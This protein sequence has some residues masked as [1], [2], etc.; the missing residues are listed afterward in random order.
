MYAQH[1]LIFSVARRKRRR[2]DDIVGDDE[3]T[4]KQLGREEGERII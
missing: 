4:V 3:A 1:T 2:G